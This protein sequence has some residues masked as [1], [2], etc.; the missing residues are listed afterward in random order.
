MLWSQFSPIFANF[1][2]K[3]WRFSQKPMLWSKFCKKLALVWAKHAN[4]FAKFLGENILK[5]IT[6]VPGHPDL[7]ENMY[8]YKLFQ[9][10]GF[11]TKFD[12][13]G[14]IRQQGQWKNGI[15][16]G[17]WSNDNRC[18]YIHTQYYSIE[19]KIFGQIKF[20]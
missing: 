14:S 20:S 9:M 16:A 18:K 13:N 12:A 17:W 2:R 7:N 8:M 19:I 6:S 1:R 10:H 4:I 5:I 3:N 15:F 11:G